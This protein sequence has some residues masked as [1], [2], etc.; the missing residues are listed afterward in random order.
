MRKPYT[1]QKIYEGHIGICIDGWGKFCQDVLELVNID[2]IGWE[3]KK[4]KTKVVD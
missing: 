4:K 3:G 2:K 1:T